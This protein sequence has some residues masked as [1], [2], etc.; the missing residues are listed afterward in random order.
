MLSAQAP[1]S[2]SWCENC[3]THN[4]TLTAPATQADQRAASKPVATA[5]SPRMP[6]ITRIQPTG[7]AK[8]S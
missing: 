2:L 6:T 8:P 5:H 7:S 1:E 3:G 4:G